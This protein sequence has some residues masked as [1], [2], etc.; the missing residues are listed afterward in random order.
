MYNNVPC[1]TFPLL[2]FDLLHGYDGNKHSVPSQISILTDRVDGSQ[3]IA[4]GGFIVMTSPTICLL[5]YCSPV[6]DYEVT[7][8]ALKA[9]MLNY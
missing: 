4:D 2:S 9:M 1:E 7:S 5:Q 8:K 6:E 3:M